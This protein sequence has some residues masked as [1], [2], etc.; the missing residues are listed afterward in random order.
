MYMM[1][2]ALRVIQLSQLEQANHLTP[3]E[4][5]ELDRLRQNL[6]DIVRGTPLKVSDPF[7]LL[8]ELEGDK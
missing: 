5:E 3:A 1:H 8:L 2:T 6:S 7:N 4:R